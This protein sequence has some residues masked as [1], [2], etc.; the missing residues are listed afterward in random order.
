M[1]FLQRIKELVTLGSGDV[2][3]SVLSAIFWFYLASQIKPDAYGEIHWFLG[4]VGIFSYV[5]LFGTLNTITVYSA[6]NIK[7]QSTLYLISLIAG[8]ILSLVVIF[9]FPSFY[10]IDSGIL[11][12]AY[13]INTL[14]LGDL[15]GRKL[16][17]TYSKYVLTQKGLTLGLGLLFF[18]YFGYDGILFALALS[19]VFYIK[20]IFII[21]REQKINF[22][23]VKERI[24]FITN[25]YMMFLLA[26]FNG[27]I[28]KIIIAP[29]LGFT[30]LGN[31]SL[32]LQAIT[33]MMIFSAIFY[34]YILPQDSSGKNTKNLKI[35]AIIVSISISLVGI[36]LGPILV[37]VFFPKYLEAK[38][39]IQIMSVSIAPSTIALI[40]ESQF[41]GS[42]KSRVVLIGAIIS[43]VILICGM[44][45]LGL[46]FGIIGLAW[47]LII[48]TSAKTVFLLFAYYKNK[49]GVNYVRT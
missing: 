11:L 42:E 8:A 47:S 21:F 7:I 12:I 44:I 29:L 17:S 10:E 2:I 23:L 45:I 20:R 33:I 36:F 40:L 46:N 18:Y 31:Y 5:A 19:Y 35:F 3:G 4:I 15:L 38:D 28:D 25:N 43:L 24:G 6:K 39:A 26:G 34:K 22:N 32:A 16:Y 14:A 48:A 41:L 9:V 30:L 27:Q 13:V 49:N 37:E 1:V